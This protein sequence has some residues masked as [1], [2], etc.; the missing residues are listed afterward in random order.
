MFGAVETKLGFNNDNIAPGT[1]KKYALDF[2][3]TGI[4]W[5]PV[6][7]LATN[8]ILDTSMSRQKKRPLG[9]LSDFAYLWSKGKFKALY[10]GLT[11]YLVFTLLFS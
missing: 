5:F 8:Q 10:A 7:V 4:M 11:P 1:F 3:W 2:S 6:G 9:I